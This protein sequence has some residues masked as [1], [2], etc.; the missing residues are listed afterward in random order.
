MGWRYVWYAS[1]G[2]VFVL[3]I[4]RITVIKLRETPKFLIGEG[5]DAEA[6]ETLQ[7]IANKY[8]R[9]CSLTLE[10]LTACGVTGANRT[11]ASERKKLY[12]FTEV[13]IHLRGLY[14][15]RKIGLSTTLIWLSWLL[16]GLAY[17]LYNVFLPS[18]LMSR[19]AEVGGGSQFIVWRNYAIGKSDPEF[20]MTIT[21]LCSAGNDPHGYV[22]I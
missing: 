18:Y 8:H 11:P 10:Q 19:G 21:S 17:P 16:I 15:T 1:G 14:T 6:V 2:L 22:L 9:P 4:L 12:I 3:S 20:S 7:F 5:R 13:G